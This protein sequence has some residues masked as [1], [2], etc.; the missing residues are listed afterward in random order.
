M[1]HEELMK[2]LPKGEEEVP[3]GGIFRIRSGEYY[4]L[5]KGKGVYSVVVKNV[6]L[7]TCGGP[8]SKEAA[9]KLAQRLN[10]VWRDDDRTIASIIFRDEL[11]E[12]PNFFTDLEK[13]VKEGSQS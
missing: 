1:A 5:E 11:R 6:E 9:T 10:E 12:N 13:R 7:V 8:Y 2:N 3:G 4:G